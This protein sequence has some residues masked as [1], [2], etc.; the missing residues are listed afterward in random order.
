MRHQNEDGWYPECAKCGNGNLGEKS[1][2]LS[3]FTFCIKCYEELKQKLIRLLRNLPQGFRMRYGETPYLPKKLIEELQH[4]TSRGRMMVNIFFKK[5]KSKKVI[6]FSNIEVNETN[7][8]EI[9]FKQSPEMEALKSDEL[10]LM[11]SLN[12]FKSA[13][14][15]DGGVRAITPN[16]NKHFNVETIIELNDSQR[17]KFY[18]GIMKVNKK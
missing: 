5:S 13:F 1:I 6:S 14:G 11:E 18:I 2:E 17:G 10:K 4:D 8:D 16:K 15:V 3:E 12:F 7:T 9:G